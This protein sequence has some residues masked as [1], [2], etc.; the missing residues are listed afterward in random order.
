M[1]NYVYSLVIIS[2]M[3]SKTELQAAAAT[4]FI[5]SS[6]NPWGRWHWMNAACLGPELD[7]AGGT[8]SV[9]GT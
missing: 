2:C 3:R 1:C 6:D 9:P 7:M 5:E 8:D 4:D